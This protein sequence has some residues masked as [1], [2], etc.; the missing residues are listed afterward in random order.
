MSTIADLVVKLGADISEFQSA[1]QRAQ[2]SSDLLLGGVLAL[3]AGILTFGV[4]AVKAAG[5]MEQTTVA[6]TTML[7][8]ADKA[9]TLLSELKVFAQTTPFEFNEIAQASKKLLAFGVNAEDIE[10]TLRRLGDV[11]SGI[12]APISEIA[13]LYGKA[14]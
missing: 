10:K 12:G 1:M 13:E 8:S 3:S 14:K 6:F 5:E 9:E 7:K 4:N 11:S 2:H